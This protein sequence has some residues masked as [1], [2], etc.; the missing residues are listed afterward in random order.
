MANEMILC[1]FNSYPCIILL[2]FNKIFATGCPIPSW[3]IAIITP[4]FKKG[5]PNDPENYRGISLLSCLAKFFYTVINNRLTTYCNVKNILS[6]S[7]LGFYTRQ[8]DNRCSSHSLQ[9]NLQILPL[10]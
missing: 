2:L 1:T 6:P 5:S 7:L 10:H 9:F 3:Y 8:L 4:I